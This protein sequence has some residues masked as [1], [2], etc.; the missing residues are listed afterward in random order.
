MDVVF[1]QDELD[2]INEQV[3]NIFEMYF[4]RKKQLKDLIKQTKDID[5]EKLKVLTYELKLLLGNQV[6][7][8]RKYRF[9]NSYLNSK[10]SSVSTEETRQTEPVED[11]IERLN[12]MKKLLDN[13]LREETIIYNTF[14]ESGYTK[15]FDEIFEYYD[16]NE[17]NKKIRKK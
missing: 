8:D 14:N 3:L 17:E 12:R 1:T 2:L 7:F 4:L 9:I 15:I 16:L 6:Q 5:D 13:V 10:K 11:R